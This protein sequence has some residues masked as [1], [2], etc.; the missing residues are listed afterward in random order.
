MLNLSSSLG[1]KKTAEVGGHVLF[2]PLGS[3]INGPFGPK[4]SRDRSN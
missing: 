1:G 4:T 2:E 3:F